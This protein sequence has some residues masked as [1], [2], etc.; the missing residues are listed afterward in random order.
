MQKLA[1]EF[2]ALLDDGFDLE[3]TG[4]DTIEIDGLLNSTAGADL[5][6]ELV[7]PDPQQRSVSR[8]GDLI[9]IDD[10][11]K[12]ADAYSENARRKVC[13]SSSP[14]PRCRVSTT[15]RRAQSFS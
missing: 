1:L 14:A 13:S 7:L 4:F 3:L 11:M 5:E 12:P 6:E 2:S 9:I 8:V 15:R 10:P